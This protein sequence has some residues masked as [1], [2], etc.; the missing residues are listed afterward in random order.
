[1]QKLKRPGLLASNMLY[2]TRSRSQAATWLIFFP[3]EQEKNATQN[4]IFN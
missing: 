1:V 2:G 4:V 3:L